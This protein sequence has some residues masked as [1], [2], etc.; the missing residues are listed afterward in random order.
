MQIAKLHHKSFGEGFPVL[1]LHGLFGMS[2][3]WK[4]FGRELSAHFRVILVD[5]RDHGLSDK[6]EAFTYEMAARDLK[7]MLEE[8]SINKV[9]IIGHS[10]GGKTAMTFSQMFPE[11]VKKLIVV[12]IS[13]IAY[14]GGHE[15]IFDAILSID[16]DSLGSRREVDLELSQKIPQVGIRQFLMKNLKRTNDGSYNW[17]ANFETL[18][19]SYSS[20]GAAIGQKVIEIPTLFVKGDQSDYILEDSVA[21]INELFINNKI[22]SIKDAGHWVHQQKPKELLKIVRDFIG[23]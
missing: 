2:D 1:I 14:K 8:E 5:Q 4:S 15:Y 7:A 3:N 21:V 18:F 11:F 10:M 9:I 23:D 20:I 6:T 22:K 17:K 13:P 19:R 12:D 16:L